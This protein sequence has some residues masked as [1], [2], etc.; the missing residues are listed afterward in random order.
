MG[1]A[2]VLLRGGSRDG[3]TTTVDDEVRRLVAPS[4]APGL[5]DVYEDTGETEHVRGNEEPAVV[6][7][8]TGQEPTGDMAPEM[9]HMPVGDRELDRDV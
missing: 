9:I 8:F 1:D 3:E 7:A 6:F 2:I 4:Q 5:V